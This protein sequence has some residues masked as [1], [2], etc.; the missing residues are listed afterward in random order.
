V[1]LEHLPFWFH[2]EA[3]CMECHTTFG[4]A[5]DRHQHTVTSHSDMVRDQE[6]VARQWLLSARRLLTEIQCI[7]GTAV[8]GLPA[9]FVSSSWCPD[10]SVNF[11]VTASALLR[12]LSA[13]VGRMLPLHHCLSPSQPTSAVELLHWHSM[14]RML[15][16]Q[17]PD[18]RERVRTLDFCDDVSTQVPAPPAVDAHCHL[19]TLA[20]RRKELTVPAQDFQPVGIVNNNV[21]YRDWH[22]APQIR[23]RHV[24]TY[25]VHPSQAGKYSLI[26]VQVPT[27]ACGVGE[28][29]LDTTRGPTDVQRS[30]LKDH[31]QL[32]RHR[33]KP[34][35]LHVRG[36][37]TLLH[38][39][40]EIMQDMSLPRSHPIYVHCLM[41][42]L[43][44]YQQWVQQFPNSVFGIS[45]RT[46]CEPGAA[47]FCKRAPLDHL[48]LES[49]APYLGRAGYD[50]LPQA[51]YLATL[52]HTS[53]R[54]IL[55]ATAHVAVRL[56]PS[57]SE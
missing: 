41:G 18:V 38:E 13:M 35:V 31:V 30:L 27:S 45:P 39:V 34:L 53:R 55:G 14:M 19:R 7:C 52:R 48:V 15:Q 8:D 16:A 43:A 32:A 2:P 49:D 1:E 44:A 57:L 33:E 42:D 9:L 5:R 28:C 29:G 21:F 51:T 11:S 6:V 46:I 36:D 24:D 12:D 4:T 50:I 26:D 17:S 23:L 10:A 3:A 22:H 20:I 37:P 25:G 56:F 47:D 54:A 40:L